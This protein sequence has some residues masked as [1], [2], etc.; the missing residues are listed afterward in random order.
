MTINI[1]LPKNWNQLTTEQLEWLQSLYAQRIAN[2]TTFLS[3]AFLGLA[4]IIVEKRPRKTEEPV[5][6]CHFEKD[7]K[8]RFVLHPYEV[9]CFSQSLKWL[10]K[11]CTLTRSPYPSLDIDG[12]KYKGPATKL[13]DFSWKQYKMASDLYTLYVNSLRRQKENRE[14]LFRFIAT[15]FT[16]RRMLFDEGTQKKEPAFVYS[17]GQSENWK[18]FMDNLK[19]GQIEIIQSFWNGCCLYLASSYPYLFKPAGKQKKPGSKE[20]MLKMEGSTMSVVMDRLKLSEQ[21]VNSSSVFTILQILDT[22]QMECEKQK[23][24]IAR[25]K[26]R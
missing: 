13:S 19:V 25:M 24:Q 6:T 26:A 18:V 7:R 17:P 2:E 14:L 22:M 12:C 8:K 15:L 5:Y 16:P 1:T 3:L 10:L 23:E 20:D 11:E 9:V 21:D 4:G